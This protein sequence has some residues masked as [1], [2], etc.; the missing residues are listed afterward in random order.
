MSLRLIFRE[1]QVRSMALP[2][3]VRVIGHLSDRD[4]QA[5]KDGVKRAFA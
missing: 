1:P 4:W 2:A 3:D 5:V